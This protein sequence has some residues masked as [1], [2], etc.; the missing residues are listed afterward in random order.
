MTHKQFNAALEKLGLSQ[1]AAARMLGMHE[2][3]RQMR[4]Y[5]AGEQAISVPVAKLLRLALAGKVSVEDIA[6]A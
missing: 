4:R 1:L 3:G 6:E 5:A 2:G